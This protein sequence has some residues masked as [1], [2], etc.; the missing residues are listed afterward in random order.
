MKKSS[1]NAVILISLI[2]LGIFCI[3]LFL[4]WPD[5]EKN[6][7][8]IAEIEKTIPKV[9]VQYIKLAPKNPYVVQYENSHLY[10]FPYN[11]DN[12]EKFQLNFGE[13]IIIFLQKNPQ[14]KKFTTTPVF[15]S[16][17]RD[18]NKGYYVLFE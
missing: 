4:I 3:L 13:A 7:K 8:E 16:C 17:S 15:Y 11:D 2:V 5:V 14:Y 10:F 1:K 18:Y 12:N 6:N 9:E